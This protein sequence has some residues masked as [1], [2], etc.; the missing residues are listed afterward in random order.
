MGSAVFKGLVF[1]VIITFVFFKDRLINMLICSVMKT[2]FKHS[3]IQF[4]H[5]LFLFIFNIENCT[6]V[7]C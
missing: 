7:F 6:R 4:L 2:E 3:H 1:E 5:L